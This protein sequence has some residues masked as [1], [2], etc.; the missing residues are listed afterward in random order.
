[1]KPFLPEY[2]YIM[3]SVEMVLLF[4]C[5]CIA[6]FLHYLFPPVSGFLSFLPYYL[7]SPVPGSRHR[8]LILHDAGAPISTLTQV[9]VRR[10]SRAA[11]GVLVEAPSTFPLLFQNMHRCSTTVLFLRSTT[12]RLWWSEPEPCGMFGHAKNL[13]TSRYFFR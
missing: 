11:A 2:A 6:F 4:G 1:M 3:F 9:R 7:F 5:V 10:P 8:R 12:P 13:K